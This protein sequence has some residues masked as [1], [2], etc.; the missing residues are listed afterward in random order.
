MFRAVQPQVYV[1]AAMGGGTGSG[2]FLD[3]CYLAPGDARIRRSCPAVFGVLVSGIAVNDPKR[4][5]RRLNHY[6]L[7]QDLLNLARPFADFYADYG[8]DEH[9]QQARPP[10]DTLYLFDASAEHLPEPRDEV[11][12]D[13]IAEFILQSAGAAVGKTF[14]EQAAVQKWPVYRGVGVF[15][16]AQPAAALARALAS[17][18]SLETVSRWFEPLPPKDA[19]TQSQHAAGLLATIPDLDHVVLAQKILDECNSRAPQSIALQVHQRIRQFAVQMADQ[20][21]HPR[22]Q[23]LGRDLVTDIKGLLG[24]DPGEE[25]ADQPA[26]SVL[27]SVIV[28]ATNAVADA[29]LNKIGAIAEAA[30]DG[31]GAKLDA[32]RARTEAL[33]KVCLRF[34]D[35]QLPPAQTAMRTVAIQSQDMIR[36]LST[37]GPTG[38]AARLAHGPEQFAEMAK[39][40][41]QAKVDYRMAEQVMHLFMVLK[42]KMTDRARLAI[43][44]DKLATIKDCLAAARSADPNGGLLHAVDLPGRRRGFGGA[45][46]E[47]LERARVHRADLERHWHETVIEPRGGL[48]AN[49]PADQWAMALREAAHRWLEEKLLAADV[50]DCFL[51]RHS[52]DGNSMP[53]ELQS[54]FEWAAPALSPPDSNVAAEEIC[55]TWLVST[56]DSESGRKLQTVLLQ[57]AP[58]STPFACSDAAACAVVFVRISR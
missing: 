14:D 48:R 44:R 35:Q 38:P 22:Q 32:A 9:E 15:T 21:D 46:G 18:L 7:A 36:R 12:R 25:E 10:T 54:F 31:P 16:L 49:V 20:H 3:V 8:G 40:Y 6:A 4:E 34:A 43:V 55:D 33:A 47:L 53:I 28:A 5:L 17:R 26:A 50:A 24:L 41:A 19:S 2:M 23:Q 30:L 51:S 29:L 11:V 56:P 1:V 57:T 45:Q 39:R 37:V 52:A 13:M 42:G 58:V 27:D